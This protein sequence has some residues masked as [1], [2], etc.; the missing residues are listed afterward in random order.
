MVKLKNNNILVKLILKYNK[1]FNN[2]GVIQRI[3]YLKSKDLSFHREKD[4]KVRQK[5]SKK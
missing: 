3:V 5:V 4:I 2:E 1:H